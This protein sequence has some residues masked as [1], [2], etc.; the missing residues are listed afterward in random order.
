MRPRHVVCDD[1]TRLDAGTRWSAV[2]LTDVDPKVLS[3]ALAEGGSLGL[4]LLVNVFHY[5]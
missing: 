1:P 5:P 3:A 2:P 4:N